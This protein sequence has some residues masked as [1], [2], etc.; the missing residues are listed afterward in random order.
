VSGTPTGAR[1]QEQLG[2]WTGLLVFA[3]LLVWQLRLLPSIRADAVSWLRWLLL[4]GLFALLW[5][6]YWRRLPARQLASRPLEILLPLICLGLPLAQAD[7]ASSL[8]RG[9]VALGGPA[10][11]LAPLFAAR[12]PSLGRFGLGLMA[13][14]EGISVVGM[15]HLGG[16]FSFFVEVRE[17]VTHGIY[18][19]VRHPLYLGELISVWG[20]VSFWP[21][22]WAVGVA[23]LLTGLQIW[24]ARLEET[25][26]LALFPAYA[27][28]REGTGF[29]WP[30]R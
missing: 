23:G 18:R 6:A 4:C 28:Y 27:P 3:G 22:F 20:F 2:R 29:L 24:R 21:S 19:F 14:G 25:Q 16:S 7:A 9:L 8:T 15:L 1:W 30:R 17:L 11:G 5:L 10:D 26:L 12:A 13:L